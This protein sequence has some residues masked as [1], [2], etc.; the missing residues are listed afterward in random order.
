MAAIDWTPL[1]NSYKGQ[2]VALKD[3]EV[4]VIAHGDN[5]SEVWKEACLII[6]KPMLVQ[7]PSD[8]IPYAG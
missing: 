7:V 3:D 2:W 8:L 4:T 6:K 5:A 1:F